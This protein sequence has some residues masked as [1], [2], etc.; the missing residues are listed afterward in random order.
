MFHFIDNKVLVTEGFLIQEFK[1]KVLINNLK[2]L[3]ITKSFNA[4]HKF[5]NNN[6]ISN[7]KILKDKLMNNLTKILSLGSKVIKLFQINLKDCK[8]LTSLKNK[9]SKYKKCS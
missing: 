2:I 5:C 9:K 3:K 8:W 4:L 1:V 6:K 7:L